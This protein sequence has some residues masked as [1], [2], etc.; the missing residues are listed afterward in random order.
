MKYFKLFFMFFG[1]LLVACD[2]E[3]E[4][5]DKSPIDSKVLI[6]AR[7]SS[8]GEIFL[9]CKTDKEYSC[10]NYKILATKQTAENSIEISF[11]AI[12]VDGKCA[13]ASGPATTT[14]NLGVLAIGEY[15][16]TF[17]SMGVSN[18]GLLIVTQDQIL[19]QFDNLEGIEILTPIVQR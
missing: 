15:G 1:L 5:L 8:S 7:E 14:I 11:E 12:E 19:L 3:D 4:G 16:L 17:N 2:K 9:D 18:K 10:F 6:S 13:T